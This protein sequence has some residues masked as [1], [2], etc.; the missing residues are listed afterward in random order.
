MKTIYFSDGTKFKFEI[1]SDLKE[2]FEK[3]N[4]ILGDRCKLG[5][6]CELGDMCE[7]EA[8]QFFSS[9]SLYKYTV[10]AHNNTVQLGCY[11]RTRAE[12]DAD[13]WN[14]P[15]E[16]PNDGSKASNARLLAYKT[17]CFFLDN[18]NK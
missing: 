5:D 11:T 15:N 10:F 16:F 8:Y 3:R 14:N 13:F 6:R 1:L 18:L 4:I 7:L 12:W 17:A 2:E 9:T